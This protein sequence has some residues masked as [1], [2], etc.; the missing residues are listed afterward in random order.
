MTNTKN[1][2]PILFGFLLGIISMKINN[3]PI[4]HFIRYLAVYL[5]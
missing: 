1:F 3:I 5:I 4:D 2:K